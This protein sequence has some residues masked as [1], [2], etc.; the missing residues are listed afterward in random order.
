MQTC[1]LLSTKKCP[2]Y[3]AGDDFWTFVFS[4]IP[5]MATKCDFCDRRAIDE[6]TMDGKSYCYVCGQE[7]NP[8]PTEKKRRR[9]STEEPAWELSLPQMMEMRKDPKLALRMLTQ[10][11]VIRALTDKEFVKENDL[12]DTGVQIILPPSTDVKEMENIMQPLYGDVQ[13]F[14]GH[15][16][17]PVPNLKDALDSFHTSHAF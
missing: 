15:L 12:E 13:F 7:E 16:S 11:M 1:L 4:P 9:V 6:F 14:T 10:A 8:L 5:I 3:K 2:V 17:V